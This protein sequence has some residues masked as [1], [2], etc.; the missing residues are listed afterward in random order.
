MEEMLTLND[1]TEL[2][3]HMI[4]TETRLF[5]YIYDMQ[6]D[7]VFNLLY[8]SEKTKKIIAD[9]YGEKTTVKGYKVLM[10][11][12]VETGDMISASMKK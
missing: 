5:L 4:E 2:N 3:G 9:R 7:E 10:S 1:G 8:D 12:S 6:M 11:I